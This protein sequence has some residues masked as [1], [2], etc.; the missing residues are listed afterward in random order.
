MC[1][2]YMHVFY[3]CVCYLFVFVC[4][5]KCISMSCS[6][7]CVWQP[8]SNSYW[9]STFWVIQGS[10]DAGC[11]ISTS[12]ASRGQM[13]HPTG[14]HRKYVL[15][16]NSTAGPTTGGQSHCP[17][18]IV[19]R[20]LRETFGFGIA[21]ILGFQASAFL[22]LCNLTASPLRATQVPPTQPAKAG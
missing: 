11:E 12:S 22:R 8:F 9:A 13:A 2:L 19:C 21:R 1:T 5:H 20:H 15:T 6:I 17:K 3:V 4:V 7:T 16:P 14:A 10:S 18:Q